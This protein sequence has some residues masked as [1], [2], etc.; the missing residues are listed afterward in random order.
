MKINKITSILVLVGITVFSLGCGKTELKDGTFKGVITKEEA[1]S[2]NA[3]DSFVEIT[4]KE[5]KIVSCKFETRDSKGNIKDSN[6]GKDSGEQN[7]K[8]AQKAVEGINK[9]PEELIKV[10]NIDDV[11]SISGATISHK[12]FVEATKKALEEAA[13]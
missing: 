3:G 7:Y 12:I 8:K 6:Y 4:V 11:D 1:D 2:K 5:G 10:Q 13:K 9:Y